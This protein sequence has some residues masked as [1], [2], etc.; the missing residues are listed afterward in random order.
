ML[1]SRNAS[2]GED[3]MQ[4]E[5]TCPHCEERVRFE[6]DQLG[7]FVPCP[8]C[9]AQVIAP[10]DWSDLQGFVLI[11]LFLLPSALLCVYFAHGSWLRW[12]GYGFFALLLWLAHSSLP[13]RG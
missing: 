6:G 13:E 7:A 5:S 4:I 8:S 1:S 9:G 12:V 2:T 3:R 10:V 11:T